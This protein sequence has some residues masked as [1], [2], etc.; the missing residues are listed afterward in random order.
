MLGRGTGGT[1]S[2][3]REF[4]SKIVVRT[5]ASSVVGASM[6]WL[7]IVV[8]YPVYPAATGLKRLLALVAYVALPYYV[9]A[10]LVC[11]RF[12][13]RRFRAATRWLVEGRSPTEAELYSLAAQ[14]KRVATS[15][16]L[17]WIGA[18]AWTMPYLHFVIRYRPGPLA[19]GKIAI[20]FA[21]AAL[22]AWTLTD[23]TVGRALRPLRAMA[24]S[25]GVRGFP[26]TMGVFP[27][28][29]LVWIVVS[30]RPLIEAGGM[31]VG[32]DSAQLER[33]VPVIWGICFASL[34][35]GIV[36]TWL[37]AR[38][39]TD[40]LMKLRHGLAAVEHGDYGIALPMDEAG[41]I[42]ALQ[43]GFNRAVQ[44]LRERERLRI[45]FG[46][47]VGAAV[48]ERALDGESRLGGETCRGTALFVDVIG[49]SGLAESM[50]PNEV[51]VL[52]NDF[53]E[54]VIRTVHRHGGLVNKLHGD[55]AL[56]V[57]G[58]AGDHAGDH[59]GQALEAARA[60]RERLERDVAPYGMYAAIGVSSGDV[61]AGNIGAL[62]RYE[63]TVIGDPVNEAS[64]LTEAAKLRESRVL[65]SES[66]FL[67]A[68]EP[69]GW[70]SVGPI[71]LRS[72]RS[73]TVAY[74]PLT[75]AEATATV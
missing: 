18:F 10:S 32:L 11:W 39:I 57:F 3:L 4:E 72:R 29:L 60:L 5:I 35:A 54:A 40:P 51:V 2:S 36:V 73:P 63:F 74:E 25:G 19:L 17:C 6:L 64:R 24:R 28:L 71:A 48:A 44:G 62:D 68:G 55:G 26:N 61:V 67:A 34:I 65:V 12:V 56:A 14:P 23:I 75:H 66:V 9:V 42:G 1:A 31:L 7:D 30:A 47:H 59:A 22:I 16:L 15:A 70:T 37:S 38:A 50:N 41:E 13:R 27:H 8:F 21:L 52:L 46:R 69:A 58:V 45:I 43:S 33:V 53:F 20:A 49:S